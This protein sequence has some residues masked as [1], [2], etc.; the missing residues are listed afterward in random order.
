M[1]EWCGVENSA[2]ETKRRRGAQE[3]AA[4]GGDR[5]RGGASTVE[6]RGHREREKESCLGAIN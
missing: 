5:G 2:R 1:A 6:E 3:V 4:E